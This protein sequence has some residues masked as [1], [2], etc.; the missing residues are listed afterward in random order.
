MPEDTPVIGQEA[1][2]NQE[3]SFFTRRITLDDLHNTDFMRYANDD[4]LPDDIDFD[5]S[6]EWVLA[7]MV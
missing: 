3:M 6:L 4:L 2:E 5:E 1:N 7:N